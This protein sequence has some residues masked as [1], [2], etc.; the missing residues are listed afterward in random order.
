VTGKGGSAGE[1]PVS[2]ALMSDLARYRV[3]HGLASTPSGN[4]TAA[5]VMSVAGDPHRH[6]TPAAVYLIVKEVF[7]R[8]ADML[9]I[10][11]PA[12]ATTLRRAST[13]WLR[14]SAAT[15][16]ADAGNDLRFIQKN[17]RHASIQTTGIYLHAEDDVRHART[18]QDQ[19]DAVASEPHRAGRTHRDAS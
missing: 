12:G 13:H 15:H 17:M 10:N 8:A 7:R 4:E 5:A 11:D 1:V 16:Q 14:H 19:G 18:V 3:F 6:L 9:A 2:T